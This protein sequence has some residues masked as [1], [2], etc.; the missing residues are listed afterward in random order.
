MTCIRMQ[1]D[2]VFIMALRIV[3]SVAVNVGIPDRVVVMSV[4]LSVV[5]M[6]YCQCCVLMCSYD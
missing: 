2:C 4:I 6:C 3:K 1:Y 5:A